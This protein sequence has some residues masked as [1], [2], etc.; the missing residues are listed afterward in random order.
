VARIAAA[1]KQQGIMTDYRGDRLRFGFAL[2][3]NAADYD[4]SCLKDIR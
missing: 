3:H 4:L 1:L 2:Y